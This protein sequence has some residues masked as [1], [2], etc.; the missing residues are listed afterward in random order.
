[1]IE[2]IRVGIYQIGMSDSYPLATA[3]LT[4]ASAGTTTLFVPFAITPR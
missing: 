4:G 2:K 3:R 1:M